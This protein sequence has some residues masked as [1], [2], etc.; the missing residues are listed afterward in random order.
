MLWVVWLVLCDR[1]NFA[2]QNNWKSFGS[3]CC[4]FDLGAWGY[5]DCFTVN[6]NGY[7]PYYWDKILCM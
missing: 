6:I 3:D 5:R 2:Y 7:T 1:A 4:K